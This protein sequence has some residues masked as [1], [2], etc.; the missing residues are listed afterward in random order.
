[1]PNNNNCNIKLNRELKDSFYSY[2]AKREIMKYPVIG[3]Y[4]SC[5]EK[6]LTG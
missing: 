6:A 2:H 3:I 1:M 4:K 5:D